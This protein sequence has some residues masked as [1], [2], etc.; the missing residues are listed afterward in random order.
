MIVQAPSPALKEG[1][2]NVGKIMIEEWVK[3]AGADGKKVLEAY[4]KM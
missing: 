4:R 2:A 3:K 1:L